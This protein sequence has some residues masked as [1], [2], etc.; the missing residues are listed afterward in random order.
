MDFLASVAISAHSASSSETFASEWSEL[1]LLQWQENTHRSLSFIVQEN[2]E[3]WDILKSP[4]H[5]FIIHSR[6]MSSSLGCLWV[7]A[8]TSKQNMN[9]DYLL[10][11]R[12][13]E[14]LPLKLLSA[15]LKLLTPWSPNSWPKSNFS[16]Q[17]IAI[18]VWYSMENLAG[19]LLSFY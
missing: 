3:F 6:V 13:N 19:D 4:I 15:G 17:F 10:L 16:F 14:C 1:K 12:L 2:F 11:S 7:S 5:F 18:C 9:T 8:C